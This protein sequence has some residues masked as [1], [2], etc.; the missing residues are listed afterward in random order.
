MEGALRLRKQ[1]FGVVSLPGNDQFA[2]SKELFNVFLVVV[3]MISVWAMPLYVGAVVSGVAEMDDVFMNGDNWQSMFPYCSTITVTNY[4]DTTQEYANSEGT[5]INTDDEKENEEA[6]K[7][8]ES[9]QDKI[10]GP[11]DETWEKGGPEGS[12]AAEWH[13]VTCAQGLGS[14]GETTLRRQVR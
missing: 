10:D 7:E 14:C 11:N 9:E 8:R 12:Q 4:G 6:G 3:V 1:C 2:A 13:G 5:V